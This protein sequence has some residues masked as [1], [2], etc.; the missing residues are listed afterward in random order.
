MRHKNPRLESSPKAQVAQTNTTQTSASLIFERV[1]PPV[2]HP[3]LG[4]MEALKRWWCDRTER[5]RGEI[6]TDKGERKRSAEDR[7]RD[8]YE[9]LEATTEHSYKQQKHVTRR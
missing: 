4:E 7:I 2:I 6:E 9:A 5:A 8:S 1:Y 3:Y